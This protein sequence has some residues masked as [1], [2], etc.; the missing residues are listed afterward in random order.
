MKLETKK[1]LAACLEDCAHVAGIYNFCQVAQQLG[2]EYEFI[3]PAVKI[4]I[5]IQKITQSSAQICAISYRLTPENGISYVKQL[6]TA[7][8]R[9]NL[10]NRTYLIGGLPKFIEQVKEFQFFSGYFI[11]GESVLEIISTLPN[12]LITE[13]GKSVFSKNLIG[14]IQQKSP[15]PIIRAHFGLP[16]L[17]STLE[18][19]TKLANSKVLDVISIAPDQPSQTWLQHPEHLKTLP[20]GVGG[21]PIRNQN[22][23]EK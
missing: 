12:E 23:L 9:N 10:E 6:I 4:P 2:Y 5:L 16:S 8:K 15:Y 21:A 13:S 14:R 17:D 19:I 18:G 22:D 3:G 7:I 11:G 1:I 20:Q